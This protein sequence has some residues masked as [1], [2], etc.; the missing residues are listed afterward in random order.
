VRLAAL[1]IIGCSLPAAAQAQWTRDLGSGYVNLTVSGLTGSQQYDVEFN[2]AELPS[3]YSQIILS[4][5]GE[6]GLIDRWLTL[7]VSSE[8]LRRSQLSDQGAT[9]GFGDTELG[10]FSGLIADPVRLTIGVEVGLPTGDHDPTAGDG[11]D[12]QANEIARSLPTGDGEFDFEPR[13]LFGYSFG[14]DAWPLSHYLSASFGYAIRTSASFDGERQAFA[15]A[16]TYHL[17]LGTKFPLP[18]LDRIWVTL[19]LHGIESFA[20]AEE[21]ARGA[22]GIGN[23]VTYTA[24]EAGLHAEIWAGFGVLLKA[25]TAFRARSIAAAIPIRGGLF[26]QF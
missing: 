7:M 24:F 1:V 12:P 10:L 9:L 5:Y 23:G 21:A 22:S 25:G 2:K 20:S 11:A 16:L 18:V 14:G 8:L 15:D 17:E 4:L 26:Y 3:T 19:K 6:V 13:V